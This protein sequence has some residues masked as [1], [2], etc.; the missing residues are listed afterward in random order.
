MQGDWI[1]RRRRRWTTNNGEETVCALVDAK[2]CLATAWQILDGTDGAAS[3]VE[4][5]LHAALASVDAIYAIESVNAYNADVAPPLEVQEF[6]GKH[7]ELPGF[8]AGTYL[9]SSMT[10]TRASP[11]GS[12]HDAWSTRRRG[13]RPGTQWVTEGAESCPPLRASTGSSFRLLCR[14]FDPKHRSPR[15]TRT[16]MVRKGSTVRVRQRA[17]QIALQCGFLFLGARG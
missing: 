6:W 13:G 9:R 8:A 2:R 15:P 1:Q 3:G 16:A 11:S 17:L 12:R 7:R 14:Y 10:A 4:H 5:A